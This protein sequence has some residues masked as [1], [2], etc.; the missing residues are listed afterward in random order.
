MKRLWLALASFGL[1][2]TAAIALSCGSST[3]PTHQLQ[4][5]TLS[6]ATADAQDYPNGEVPFV[7][8]GHY[9]IAPLTVTPLSAT[10]G[11]CYQ[12]ASTSAISVTTSGMAQCAS[13]ASG[14]YTVWANDPAQLGPGVYSCTAETACGG[15]CMV[16][17]SA[18]LT[19]P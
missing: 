9:N 1:M 2:I 12:F 7:A 13:G 5:I 17:G 15:G 16:Q 6:P 8:S 18:Q 4:S 14:T 3:P 10:W 19:C 11:T